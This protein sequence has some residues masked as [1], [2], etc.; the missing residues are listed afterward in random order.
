MGVGSAKEKSMEDIS[1]SLV[2]SK[3]NVEKK[4]FLI[5][6]FL[7][8]FIYFCPLYGLP[9][10]NPSLPSSFSPFLSSFHPSIFPLF[11]T[12]IIRCNPVSSFLF[13]NCFPYPRSLSLFPTLPPSLLPSSLLG[14]A[15]LAFQPLPPSLPSP[16]IASSWSP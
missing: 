15:N 6:Y 16:M 9:T 11:H 5:D 13:L 8:L 14:T 12:S 10:A 4:T 7:S 3:P 1:M 2:L